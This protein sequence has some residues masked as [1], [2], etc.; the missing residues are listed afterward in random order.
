ITAHRHR[1]TQ[2]AIADAVE[3]DLEDVLLRLGINLARSRCLTPCAFA[4]VRSL[5]LT[6]RSLAMTRSLCFTRSVL[7]GRIIDADG[8]VCRLSR[9]VFLLF[10]FPARRIA[11]RCLDAGWLLLLDDGFIAL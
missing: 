5:C 10:A 3:V 8:F 4:L 7:A 2:D 1:Q 9:L 11:V 6:R